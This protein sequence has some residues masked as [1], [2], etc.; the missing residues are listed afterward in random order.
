M[1]ERQEHLQVVHSYLQRRFSA[2]DWTFSLPRGQGMETYFAHGNGLEY[3]VKVG[4]YVERYL[5]MAEMGLTPPALSVGQLESGVPILVQP[6]VA[7]RT[8]SRLDFQNQS[9]RVAK[10]I[11]TLH[12]SPRVNSVLPPACSNMHKDAGQQAF[13]RL[14]LKWKRY[15][16]QVPDVSAFVDD[17]LDELAHEIE[18]FP[19]EGLAA[20]HN[21]ICNANWLFASDG[22]IYLIDLDSM[23]MDDPAIDLGALLWWYYP[24]AARERFLD[25]AGY[26]YDDVFKLRMRVRMALHCLSILLPREQS[27]DD[28]QSALFSTSLRDFRAVLAG[29]EN[30]EGYTR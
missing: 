14:L 11:R 23:S 13:D 21:D 19:T 30:P 7:G 26:P 2:R 6:F 24:P 10:L 15:K 22:K 17:R 1:P 25:I 27:F 3:F 5:V 9:E 12:N 28:F 16:S 4:A 20:C 8:P 29:E 18:Q